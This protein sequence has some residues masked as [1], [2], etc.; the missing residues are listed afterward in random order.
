MTQF[1]E[2]TGVVTLGGNPITLLG[3]EI[4]VKDHSTGLHSK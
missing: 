2:R 1:Q 4:Q 3:P